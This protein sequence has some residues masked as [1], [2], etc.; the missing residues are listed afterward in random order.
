MKKWLI[1]LVTCCFFATLTV[2]PLPA[3]AGSKSSAGSNWG[4]WVQVKKLSY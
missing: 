2:Q 1:A 4:A 3:P